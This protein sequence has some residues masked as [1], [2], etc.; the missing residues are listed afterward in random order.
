MNVVDQYLDAMCFNTKWEL[1]LY[2]FVF[3][4]FSKK[5]FLD[6]FKIA[7][8]ENQDLKMKISFASVIAFVNATE[9]EVQMSDGERLISGESIRNSS[10]VISSLPGFN[11]QGS[12][13][14]VTAVACIT[15]GASYHFCSTLRSYFI[16]GKIYYDRLCQTRIAK[17]GSVGLLLVTF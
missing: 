17:R 10:D 11:V 15:E 2:T 9:S 12:G 1:H 7:Q 16:K 13:D 3:Q 8:L 14:T 5:I 6:Y 4:Y